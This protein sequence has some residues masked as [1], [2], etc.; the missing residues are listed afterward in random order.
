MSEQMTLFKLPDQTQK[1]ILE[2]KNSKP[3]LNRACRNQYELIPSLLED[4]L[5]KDHLARSV[6]GYV[7]S[8]D[9]SLVLSK[10][11]AVENHVGR[12]A[13]DPK[14]LLSIWLFAIIKGIGSSRVIEEY[15]KEHDAFKWIC[16]GV[17]VNYH[18]IS[19]F[20]SCHSDQLDLLLTMSV[21]ALANSGII[22]LEKVSQ[23]GM[24]VRANAGAGSFKR[25]P[26]I[27][28]QYELAK[29]LVDDIKEEERKNPGACKT[30]LAAAELRSA[31]DRLKR[32]ANAKD[33]LEKIRLE[34][35]AYAKKERKKV[36]DTELEKVRVSTTDCEA[37]IM[38][39]AC[40]GFRP[41]YN[42][43]FASTN[44][45]KAIIGLDVT[46]KGCDNHQLTK[47]IE[48]VKLRY[49]FV[50]KKWFV[51]GGFDSHEQLNSAGEKYKDCTVYMPVKVTAKNKANPYARQPKDSEIVGEWRERMSTDEA[52]ELYKERAATAEYSNAQARNR[53]LQ[54]FLVRSIEKT[55]CVALLFAIAHNMM[56]S[57]GSSEF[58]LLEL[59]RG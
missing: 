42:V 8:L 22:S 54:Q 12:P 33:E 15:C 58:S 34:K 26:T 36:N 23:D 40:G 51:D 24:R 49:E 59:V 29:A 46:N 37:R 53:G 41:A 38:K 28:D 9:L 10:I 47:M 56:I 55:K 57:I 13:T 19:D 44:I 7:D 5:P 27:I 16:G 6:W 31:E 17:G 39:M 30:R 20:R 1:P 35:I 14:I 50:P 43:Q 3:R 48:Q 4:L 25:E 18:T 32:L 52:K 45:G 2:P 11:Q 21:T